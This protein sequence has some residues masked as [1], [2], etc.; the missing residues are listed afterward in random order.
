MNH[1]I[2]I[3]GSGY[4]ANAFKVAFKNQILKTAIVTDRK[5]E[6]KNEGPVYTI[7][8]FLQFAKAGVLDGALI[9]VATGPGSPNYNQEETQLWLET[10][11]YLINAV[12]GQSK[13][14][15]I[16]LVSSGGA[17]YVDND[18]ADLDESATTKGVTPYANY[19]IAVEELYKD[20][21]NENL[22]ILRFTNPYGILQFSKSNQGLI[23]T[24]IK[25]L[26]NN[27]STVVYGNGLIVR[28]YFYEDDLSSIVNALAFDRVIGT[29]NISSGLGRSQIEVIHAIESV[30]GR[31]LKITYRDADSVHVKINVL[32]PIRAQKNLGWTPKCDLLTGLG[33]I[34]SKICLT[35]HT[36]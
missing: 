7:R 24:L 17:I 18:E 22:T 10:Q 15:H 5:I 9:L 21:L 33:K 27:E 36:T 3:I 20:S 4:I 12:L 34:R 13:G 31:K 1:T 11:K 28:D 35:S 8:E 23:Q 32:S 14:S 19:Q 2:Y 25:S 16:V 26:F 30:F 29:Y 6:V